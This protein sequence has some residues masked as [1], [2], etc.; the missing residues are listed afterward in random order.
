MPTQVLIPPLSQTVDTLIFV[1]WYKQEGETV[2]QGEPLFVVETDKATLDV[3]AP[4]SGVL[5]QV[6]AGPGD[7]VQTLSAI[8]VIEVAES[9]GLGT[10]GSSGELR[11]TQGQEVQGLKS[12]EVPPS[13]SEL[14]SVPPSSSEFLRAP[15]RPFASP[16]ARRLAEQLGVPLAELTGTGPDGAIV[17]RDV[18]ANWQKAQG[19]RSASKTPG[20][21]P[22]ARRIAEEAG[23][24]WRSL[25]G[26]GPAGRITRQDLDEALAHV[27][28]VPSVPQIPPS[29]P[30]DLVE[31]IPFRGVRALIAERMQASHRETAPVTLTAEVDASEL[32]GMRQRL[33]EQHVVVSYNDLLITILARALREH[34]Q[35]NASLDGDAIKLWRRIDIGLAVDTDRGLLVAVVR[36]ADQKGLAQLA[37]ETKDLA[38]RARTGKV[39]PDE[40]RGGTFTLTNLGMLGIDTFTPIINLP[41]TAILGVGRIKDKPAVRAGQVVVRQLMWLSLTFDHR[42]VD[43]GLAARFLQRVVQ[44]VEQPM[45][46]LA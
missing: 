40:L 38:E 11:G 5:R 35:L 27:P 43:G 39:T 15:V 3:E 29:S 18:Q 37:Q 33:A 24:D 20:I 19:M 13:I 23:V 12:L 46:L 10:Q 41:E 32:V 22:V 1:N 26:S 2:L 21:T 25:E 14:P 17:E 44:L 30:D 9:V 28:Q 42:L 31:T 16:R 45:L 8:A 6:T 4:A 36:S 7:E 34:P